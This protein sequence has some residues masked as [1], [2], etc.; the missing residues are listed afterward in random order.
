MGL[1]TLHGNALP[2]VAMALGL[3]TLHGNVLPPVAMV[4]L[5]A[6]NAGGT[7]AVMVER[8]LRNHEELKSAISS[9]IGQMNHNKPQFTGEDENSLLNG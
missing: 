6:G 8:T 7:A 9:R 3:S 4:L 5:L 1:S 2:P